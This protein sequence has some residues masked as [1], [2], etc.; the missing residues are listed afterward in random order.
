MLYKL[1]KVIIRFGM[2]LYYREI[3]VK[4]AHVL[5]A[6]S[7][8]MIIIANHPNTLIDAWMIGRVCKRQI[9][10]MT[11]GTFFNSPW[12][13]RLLMSL[14]MIPINRQTDGNTKGVENTDS[15]E[16]CYRILEKGQ[17][18]VVFPEGNSFQEHSLRT[19]KT[20]TARIALEVQRRNQGK[21]DL[22]IVPV[23]LFYTEAHRFRS[24][25]MMHVGEPIPLSG[26][27]E[28]PQYDLYAHAK[29]LTEKFRT[30]LEQLLVMSQSAEQERLLEELHEI[31]KEPDAPDGVEYHAKRMKDLGKRLAEIQVLDPLKM[32]EI[33]RLAGSFVYEKEQLAIREDLLVKGNRKRNFLR[34]SSLSVLFLIIGLPFFLFGFLH[35]VLPFRLTS[36]IVPR[37]TPYIEYY[38]P[39]S[40]LLGLILYPLNYT[41]LLDQASELFG[42]SLGLKCLYFAAMPITGMYAFY[43]MHLVSA[44]SKRM[45]FLIQLKGNRQDVND[46]RRIRQ[47]LAEKIGLS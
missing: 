13:K 3:K 40:I 14:G 33:Q 31:L 39:L 16:A 17:T 24:A 37:L 11:K 42:L 20:G 9:N 35:N 5:N 34:E 19:L 21:L 25:V 18:L 38:A 15:F 22:I 6:H 23:G 45:K 7:G 8:P 46:L 26:V 4:N 28:D 44:F 2:F 32:E 41:F 30:G 27:S 10:Y 1:L 47:A 43:Y 12:K 36:L 29:Q